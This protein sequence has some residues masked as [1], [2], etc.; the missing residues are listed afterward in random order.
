MVANLC[1]SSVAG[2]VA[3]RGT[4]KML[5]AVGGISIEANGKWSEPKQ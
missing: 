1:V 2:Q 5:P 3:Y 4:G